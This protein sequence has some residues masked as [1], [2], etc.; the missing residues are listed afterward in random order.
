MRERLTHS[1]RFLTA[2]AVWTTFGCTAK[3]GDESDLDAKDGTWT[4]PETGL[5]WQEPQFE[6]QRNFEQVKTA[7]AELTLKGYAGPFL[8]FGVEGLPAGSFSGSKRLHRR[9]WVSNRTLM[10]DFPIHLRTSSGRRCPR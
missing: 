8:F 3:S 7:C 4:D 6:E 5:M 2:V 9:M 10:R 1:V